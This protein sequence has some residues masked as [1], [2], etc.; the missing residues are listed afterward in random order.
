MAFNKRCEGSKT[1]VMKGFVSGLTSL[2]TDRIDLVAP[3]I[4]TIKYDFNIDE[5]D[6]IQKIADSLKVSP[7]DFTE[8]KWWAKRKE[9]LDK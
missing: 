6:F 1:E 8:M 9:D 7:I 2:A 3:G 5:S 4:G